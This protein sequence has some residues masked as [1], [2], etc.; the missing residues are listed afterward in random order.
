MELISLASFQKMG[1]AEKIRVL[2]LVAAGTVRLSKEAELV[3]EMFDQVEDGFR[4][5]A[6]GKIYP[7]I[8]SID[9]R[10]KDPLKRYRT[11]I[12]EDYSKS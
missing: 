6:S 11:L 9:S 12:F 8:E 3:I 4:E 1:K 2:K 5:E 10:P 7:S